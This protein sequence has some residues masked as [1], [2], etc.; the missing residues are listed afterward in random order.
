MAVGLRFTVAVTEAGAV[1]SFGS[2]DGSLGHGD[3]EDV[4]LPKRIQALDGLHVATVAAG[5][6][7]ALALTRCGRVYSWGSGGRHRSV[8]G[9]GHERD[10]GGDNDESDDDTP[11]TPELITALLGERV[12]AIVAGPFI[13]CAITDAGALFTWGSNI[14]GNL[15]HGDVRIR[16]R[17]TVVSALQGI[18][19]VGVSIYTKHAL[20]LVADG[21]VYSF[22]IGP[23]LGF[24]QKGEQ[25]T[26]SPKRIPHLAC[27]V[28]RR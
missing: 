5:I 21:S 25:A 8:H 11:S 22:G 12:R 24:R 1:Y 20:A 19:V 27:M 2:R 17:P 15:G 9:L 10:D 18:R 4:F 6:N 23:A 16:D 28:P 3:T 13:S 26:P 7:H 14:H